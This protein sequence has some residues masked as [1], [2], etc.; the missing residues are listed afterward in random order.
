MTSTA[1]SELEAALAQAMASRLRKAGLVGRYASAR[2]DLGE[3]V[4][5]LV[6]SGAGAYLW[7]LPGR[8]KTWA[9]A[10]VVREVI[11][12]SAPHG[13]VPARLVTAKALL[14]MVRDGFNGGDRG[15]L[16]RVERVPVLAL[17]DLGAETPT[18]FS[19]ETLTALLDARYAA[20]LPTV[21]TSNLSLGA[22]RDLWG[23]LGG[24]R[25][26]SRIAGM[27]ERIEV[28]GEDGRRLHG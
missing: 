17:D 5:G 27:C 18:P 15:A 3:R 28:A 23:G 16:A 10:H 11:E 6:R 2:S 12:S 9:A 24:A 20:G 1:D 19:V 21:V 26:A 8:G 22:L 13:R 25:A 4:L 14:D 7:G